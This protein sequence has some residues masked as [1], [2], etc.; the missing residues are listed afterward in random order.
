MAYTFIQYG[1]MVRMRI[2]KKIIVIKIPLIRNGADD[3]G[4]PNTSMNH[5]QKND[6]KC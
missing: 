5:L 6:I 1:G 4:T 2:M 3:L